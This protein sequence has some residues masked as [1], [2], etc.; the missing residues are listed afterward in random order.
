MPG[1]TSEEAR[2][3]VR[4][5]VLP[6]KEYLGLQSRSRLSLANSDWGIQ[7]WKEESV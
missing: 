6:G 7:R 4:H 5:L 2:M 1:S 3:I